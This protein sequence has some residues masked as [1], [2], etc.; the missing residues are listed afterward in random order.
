VLEM[1]I[2]LHKH[3]KLTHKRSKFL[4]NN[5]HFIGDDYIPNDQLPIEQT[6]AHS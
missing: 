4:H 5:V 1:G 3:L 2:I 6:N